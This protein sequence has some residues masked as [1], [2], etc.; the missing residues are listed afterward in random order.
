MPTNVP[1]EYVVAEQ[2]YKKASTVEEKIRALRMML[3]YCPKHKGCEN[4]R[5]EI[6]SKI[7]KLKAKL[8]KQVKKRSGIKK[9]GF[10]T[11]CLIGPPNSGKSTLLAKL[12]NAKPK[13]APYPFTT[14]KPVIG[15]LSYHGVK[16]QVIEVPPLLKDSKDRESFSIIGISDLVVVVTDN[17]NIEWLLEELKRIH[18]NNYL[19]VLNKADINSYTKNFIKISALNDKDIAKLKDKIWEHLDLIRVYTKEPGKK[20]TPEPFCLKKGS[21]IRDL[22]A[23]IHKDFLKKFKFARVWGSG[24]F[25]GIQV[26][27]DHKLQD[28]DIIELHLKKD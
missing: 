10:A 17:E 14:T 24:K 6:K 25:P 15:M 27:L 26:G 8:K 16:L 2:N 11:I 9:E 3:A 20:P 23:N 4:L 1:I 12:T 13:I 28:N 21:T 5:A 19:I 18:I 22:A 7:S